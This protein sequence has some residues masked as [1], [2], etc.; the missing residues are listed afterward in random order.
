MNALAWEF[1]QASAEVEEREQKARE[2]LRRRIINSG[3]DLSCTPVSLTLS[4]QSQ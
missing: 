4:R 3:T 1:L 2:R